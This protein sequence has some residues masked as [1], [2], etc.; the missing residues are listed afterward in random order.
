MRNRTLSDEDILPFFK[1]E[2]IIY[3]L[4]KEFENQSNFSKNTPKMLTC[5]YNKNYEHVCFPGCLHVAHKLHQIHDL[6]FHQIIPQKQNN[7]DGYEKF[8]PNRI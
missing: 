6:S 8:G 4:A 1:I 2:D 5:L 3:K 7:D